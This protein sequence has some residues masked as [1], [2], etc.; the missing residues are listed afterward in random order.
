MPPLPPVQN[1]VGWYE[2][3]ADLIPTLPESQF[4]SWQLERMPELVTTSLVESR[5]TIRQST[6][7]H[8]PCVIPRAFIVD[9]T[10]LSAGLT[11]RHESEPIFTITASL[12]RRPLRAWLEQGRVVALTPRALARLQSF[13]DSY[14]LPLA[15]TL[16]SRVVGNAVP[17]LFSQKLLEAIAYP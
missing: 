8:R 2:A 16:A 13:P 10:A 9:G 6:V 14:Q 7:R 11:I 1:W 4:A 3:V 15:R 12:E 17:P 5:N